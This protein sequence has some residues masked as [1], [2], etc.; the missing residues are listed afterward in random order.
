MALFTNLF[1]SQPFKALYVIGSLFFNASRLPLWILKYAFVRQHPT[2]TFKQA[3]TL[4]VFRAFIDVQSTIRSQPAL[5]LT[6][7]KEGDQ[8]VI[9]KRKDEDKDKFKGPMLANAQTVQPTDIGGVWYPAPLTAAEVEKRDDLLVILHFHGGAYV[10]GDGRIEYS[11]PIARTLL[12]NTPATH[13]LLPSYRLSKL[14]PGPD[15]NPFPAALQDALTSY[16][17]LIDELNI[18]ASKI[19]LG[20]DSAG[21]NCAIALLRYIAEFGTKIGVPQPS[22]ALLWSPWL[23]PTNPDTSFEYN[24]PNFPSDYIPASFLTWGVAALA[25]QNPPLSGPSVIASNPYAN[26]L[27]YG[28]KTPVPLWVNMGGTEVLCEDG[29]KWAEMM[30]G[31]GNEVV[32]DVEDSVC[33]DVLLV[34]PIVGMTEGVGR[35]AKRAGEWLKGVR[36]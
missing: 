28:F 6:P 10:I 8:F 22:A 7:G 2:W 19:A 12:E 27:E 24:N 30:K 16:L 34:A 1:A 13:V 21:G 5:P 11:G 17:Y 18:P 23:N 32:F 4:R 20:G 14:P 25:G 29:R 15:S 33:H 9:I 36:K 3:V 26:A 35:M 31:E